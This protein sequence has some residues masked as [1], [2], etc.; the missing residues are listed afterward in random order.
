MAIGALIIRK[1]ARIHH[2]NEDGV[3]V[4]REATGQFCLETLRDQCVLRRTT[5]IAVN[6]A[7]YEGALSGRC[8]GGC[9]RL[10]RTRTGRRVIPWIDDG[11]QRELRITGGWSSLA[12]SGRLGSGTEL[13]AVSDLPL[14]LSQRAARSQLLIKAIEIELLGR[15]EGEVEIQPRRRGKDSLPPGN[16]AAGQLRRNELN[17]RQLRERE[18]RVALDYSRRRNLCLLYYV[19]EF[20]SDEPLSFQHRRGVSASTENNVRTEGICFCAQAPGGFH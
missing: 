14:G 17:V 2:W 16:I 12:T 5:F 13:R 7:N 6:A 10:T 15:S 11:L 1:A 20:V 8:R 18:F 3:K 4:A 9:R 19:S